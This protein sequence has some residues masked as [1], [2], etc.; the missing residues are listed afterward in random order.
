MHSKVVHHTSLAL[1]ELRLPVLRFNFRGAGLSEGEHDRG[2]GEAE[3]VRSMLDWLTGE[4]PGA[5]IVLAGFSFGAWV[6]MRVGCEDSR[7]RAVIGVGVPAGNSD[8]SYLTDCKKPKLFVQGANDQFGSRKQLLDIAVDIPGQTNV[9]F[10]EE[11]DHFFS[12]K[13]DDFRDAMLENLPLLLDGI[14]GE[15]AGE[16]AGQ[17]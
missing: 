13:L 16:S 2:R 5:G 15:E 12:G 8:L 11:A 17:K 6:G 14:R 7:V 10:V 9:A 1:Q 3:D 4:M